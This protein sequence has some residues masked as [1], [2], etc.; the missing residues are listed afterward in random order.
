MVLINIDLSGLSHRDE[1]TV[2]HNLAEF[3]TAQDNPVIIIG[4]FGIP[5]LSPTLSK[6]FEQNRSGS[7]KPRYPEQ[8]FYWFNPFGV[9]SLNVLA[10][11]NFGVKDVF[12][13]EQRLAMPGI[14]C[15]LN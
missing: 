8:R 4:E 12:F 11:K 6:S 14:R 15:W 5:A 13:A 9:P 10:Y 2:Y 7:Q 3:V 1:K